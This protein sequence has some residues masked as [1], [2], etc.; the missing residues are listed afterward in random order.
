MEDD[1]MN[2]D[3]DMKK[4]K[5]NLWEHIKFAA[6]FYKN[7]VYVEDR[8]K[9]ADVKSSLWLSVAVIGMEIWLLIRYMFKYVFTGKCETFQIFL[10]YTY[11]YWILLTVS[12]LLAV[13]AIRYI[14]GKLKFFKK[15]S[16]PIIFSYYLVG[17]YFGIMTSLV[18]F[19]KGK[20]IICFLAMSLYATFIFVVRPY[21]SLLLMG[22]SSVG[23]ILIINNLV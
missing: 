6:G 1:S 2:T 3:A 22:F 13:Y 20:M 8:L 11:S 23:F 14:R 4:E 16:R 10:K 18:D 5:K 19:S 15:L 21:I 17:I 12:V 7:P 9:E